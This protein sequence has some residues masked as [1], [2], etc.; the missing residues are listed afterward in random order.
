[1]KILITGG[2]GFIGINFVHYILANHINDLVIVLDILNYSSNPEEIQQLKKYRNFEFIRGDIRNYD[3]IDK[4]AK[5]INV[6]INFAAESH[7]DRSIM[8][9]SAFFDTNVNGTINLLSVALKNKIDR[10]IQIS[11][12][13][14]YGSIIKG[15]SKE[16]DTL[17][18][19]S[20]YSSSKAAADLIAMSYYKTYGLPVIITRSSNNFGPYQHPEKFIPLFITNALDNQKLPLYGD[21]KNIRNWI[22]VEDN[23]RGIDLVLRKGKPGEIYNIGGDVEMKNIDIVKYI[24]N[25]LGKNEDLIQYVDDRPAHDRRYALDSGKIKKLGWKCRYNFEEALKKTIDWYIENK[26]WWQKRKNNLFKKYYN[27][28]YKKQRGLK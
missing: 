13:E 9:P 24:L 18:P 27:S 12:D 14:V 21:G 19:T 15:R 8:N 5:K 4:V 25:I 1:M 16:K 22:Y 3:L 28:W 6:I 11:T 7:V 17:N 10:F 26:T 23:C 2:A 20:P